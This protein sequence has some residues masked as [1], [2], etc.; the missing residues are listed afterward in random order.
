MIGKQ[1]APNVRLTPKGFKI[2]GDLLLTDGK[3]EQQKAFR[4]KVEQ[5]RI[6]D[7]FKSPENLA[8]RVT[9]DLRKLV[10]THEPETHIWPKAPL[11]AHPYPL[12]K[13]FTGHE[14]ERRM[15]TEWYQGGYRPVMVVEAIGGMGKSVLSW[16]WLH[17][18]CLGAKLAGYPQRKGPKE[19]QV[20]EE[21]RPEGV[22]YWSFYEQDAHFGAF[23][24][25]AAKYVGAPEGLSERD[26]LEAL[27]GALSQR[28]LLLI[29][30]GFER[31][32]RA[33][34]GYRAPYQG[35]EAGDDADNS[36][37][38][39]RA[40]VFLKY[41]ANLPLRGRVL[42]TSRLLPNEL[43]DLAGCRRELLTD[44]DV[45]D[46]VTYFQA[47]GV[48][49]TRAEIGDAVR[50]YGGH[51]LSMNLLAKAIVNDRKIRGDI[52]AAGRHSVFE[53]LQGQSKHHVL[54]MAFNELADDCR[55]LLGR[56]AAFRSPMDYEAIE[57]IASVK[58]GKLDAALDEL[59]RRG[60]LLRDEKTD[61]YDLHPI[62]RGYAY[63]RLSDKEGVH[64]RLQEYF[65]AKPAPERVEKL[66][67]LTPTI[68]LYW[69]MVGAGRLD[70]AFQLYQDRLVDPTYFRFGAYAQMIEL[71]RA[72]FPDGEDRPPR[73]EKEGIRPGRATSSALAYANSGQPR[74]AVPLFETSN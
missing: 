56:L 20:A 47:V 66:E 31:E 35:D 64:G 41:A 40:A 24:R 54:E 58:C 39:P 51:P 3:A 23:L 34:S 11:I 69:H 68:E 13:G 19:L 10:P 9:R 46:V 67:D 72:L 29:L 27:L 62:V 18:D 8:R 45:E 1:T 63:D 14:R 44:F 48:K 15:L 17:W 57:A 26:K 74:R 61:R 7:E 50:P 43:K 12:Q 60:L 30:D 5:A 22:L 42:L 37:V 33:Y 25:E 71:L 70:A 59:E 21:Q 55:E 32:L 65:E 16:V 53:K 4:A 38:D 2:D 73:L 49:G 52:R 6:R 36:C 28:R